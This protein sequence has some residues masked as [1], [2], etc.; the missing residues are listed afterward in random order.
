MS[1]FRRNA[2]KRPKMSRD[3]SEDDETPKWSMG[4]LNDKGTIEVP[5]E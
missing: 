5:G 4:V 1:F 3:G 2:A